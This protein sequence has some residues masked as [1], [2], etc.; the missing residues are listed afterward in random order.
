VR[1]G[2]AERLGEDVLNAGR[3]EN[4]AN[5]TAGDD[6]RTLPF[7]IAAGTSLALPDPKPTLPLPSP[8]TT[9]ALKLKFLPPLTTFVTRLIWTTLS[10]IPL[11]L[12]S[13]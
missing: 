10:I 3:L 13:S 6:A 2:G 9:S 11:S 5:R 12:R 7:L 8:T 4:R 1:I